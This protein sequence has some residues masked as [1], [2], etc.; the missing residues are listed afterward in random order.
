VRFDG[1][2]IRQQ[3]PER[4]YPG[5]V[6]NDGSAEPPLAITFLRSQDMPLAGFLSHELSG[7][8]LMK[9]FTRSTV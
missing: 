1:L 2:L 5:F 9:P 7:A 3:T 6:S 4:C 8:G